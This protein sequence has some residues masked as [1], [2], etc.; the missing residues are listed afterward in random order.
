MFI[1]WSDQALDTNCSYA[2]FE[3]GSTRCAPNAPEAEVGYSDSD[4][5]EPAAYVDG[6]EPPPYVRTS[7]EGCAGEL[8]IVKVSALGDERPQSAGFYQLH[9]GVCTR[10]KSSGYRVFATTPASPSLFASA[11]V[12]TESR[13]AFDVE[14]VTGDDGSRQIGRVIDN[15]RRAACS[16]VLSSDG[17]CFLANASSGARPSSGPVCANASFLIS[18]LRGSRRATRL[19]SEATF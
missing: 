19:F 12:T 13:G 14:L 2:R 8:P 4:C 3:D 17:Q 5:T 16:T 1:D 6:S 11:R 18:L 10:L 7:S 15:S 9:N